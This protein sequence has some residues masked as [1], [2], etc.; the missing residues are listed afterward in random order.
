MGTDELHSNMA[1]GPSDRRFSRWYT[2]D[3]T[4]WIANEY[5]TLRPDLAEQ[6]HRFP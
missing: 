2:S 1:G 6:R 5:K 4:R 3:L